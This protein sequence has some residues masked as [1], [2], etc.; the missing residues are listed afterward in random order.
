MYFPFVFC[1][2]QGFW[3]VSWVGHM[4]VAGFFIN[5]ASWDGSNAQLNQ[6]AFTV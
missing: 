6:Y 2:S 5:D 3:V 4:G 1:A